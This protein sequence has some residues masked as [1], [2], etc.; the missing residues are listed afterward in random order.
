L[1]ENIDTFL[2][3]LDVCSIRSIN[4]LD[5]RKITILLIMFLCVSCRS[6][7]DT[8]T[9]EFEDFSHT[10]SLTT[11]ALFEAGSDGS[12]F[13]GNIADAKVLSDGTIAVLDSRS[14][15]IHFLTE[16]GEFIK[17]L[18]LEGRGPG[19]VQN[20]TN[21]LRITREDYIAVRDYLMFKI[22]IFQANSTEIVHVADII[23]D[24]SVGNF[25][26]NGKDQLLLKKSTPAGKTDLPEP[27]IIIDVD[28]GSSMK[29]V[30]EFP[31]FE[32][33]KLNGSMGGMD[34]TISNSTK[35]HTKNE[36]CFNEDLLYH[37]RTDSV[38][39]TSY[40]VPDGE[41]VSTS[42]LKLPTMRL[43]EEEKENLIDNI[44]ASGGDM[45]GNREKERLIS[46]MPDFKPLVNRVICDLPDGIWFQINHTEI[47]ENETWLLMSNTGE[48]KGRYVHGNESDIVSI[49]RGKIFNR[50]TDDFGD[51]SMKVYRY[52]LGID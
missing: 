26:L 46:E 42:Y 44:L 19:E 8:P 40:S 2:V 47:S 17:T 1:R 31:A 10:P 12:F 41:K 11:E 51:Y 9:I 37:V 27:I 5:M 23:L 4:H 38:G 30:R 7:T 29:I 36:F 22:S 52:S 20:L 18:P 21:G 25:F 43:T 35:Y 48:I 16:H 34:F 33:L 13:F 15:A 28:D 6:S 14:L 50:I 45:W 24:Y 49:H 3:L 32:Q 39:F